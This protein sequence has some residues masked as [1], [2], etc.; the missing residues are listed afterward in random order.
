MLPFSNVLPAKVGLNGPAP[1]DV[2]ALTDILYSTYSCKPVM[3]AFLLEAD[4][5]TLL[6]NNTPSKV[7]SGTY[8]I[9]NAIRTPF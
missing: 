2:Y 1:T 9:S 8:T 4:V 5:L 6:P 3:I 7:S